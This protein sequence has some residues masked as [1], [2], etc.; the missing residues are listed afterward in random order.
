MAW[1][2]FS[3]IKTPAGGWVLAAGGE[4]RPV[5]WIHPFQPAGVIPELPQSW[6]D[7]VW[8]RVC[9]AGLPAHRFRATPGLADG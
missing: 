3:R 6:G 1:E 5:G 2:N 8:Q 9:A 4:R 7:P